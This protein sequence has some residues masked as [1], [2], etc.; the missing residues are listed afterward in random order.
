MQN[1]VRCA[2]RPRESVRWPS[3]LGRGDFDGGDFHGEILRWRVFRRR[4]V[5]FWVEFQDF[6]GDL[7]HN[8]LANEAFSDSE[9]VGI[10]KNKPG[11][12]CHAFLPKFR[13]GRRSEWQYNLILRRR[14]VRILPGSQTP[15]TLPPTSFAVQIGFSSNGSIVHAESGQRPERAFRPLISSLL[16]LTGAFPLVA[17]NK[18]QHRNSR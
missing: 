11:A 12:K 10:K 17:S 18:G 9:L 14:L 6:L 1:S 5:Q 15:V 7:R 13:S 2:R 4:I 16:S 8:I 3:L